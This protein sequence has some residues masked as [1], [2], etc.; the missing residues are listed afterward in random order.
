MLGLVLVVAAC[1]PSVQSTPE[2]G[3][4]ATVTASP[5][6]ALVPPTPDPSDP[7]RGNRQ[8]PGSSIDAIKTQLSQRW[9]LIFKPE[10]RCCDSAAGAQTGAVGDPTQHSLQLIARF[11]Y[12]S[13]NQIHSMLFIGAGST[14][15]NGPNSQTREFI[16][17]CLR[18][19]ITSEAWSALKPWLD[20]HYDQD[21]ATFNQAGIQIE[22]QNTEHMERVILGGT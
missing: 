21:R 18:T 11:D 15:D 12:D 20:T 7:W 6:G 14:A 2:A 3:T 22:V 19:S 9:G 13:A 16:Y 4:G 10:G 5:S 8:I 1:D 17:D